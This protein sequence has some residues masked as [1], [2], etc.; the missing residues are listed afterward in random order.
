MRHIL[1]IL[2]FLLLSSFLVSCEKKEGTLYYHTSP[3]YL[4]FEDFHFKKDE[5]ED[6]DEDEYM[7]HKVSY[8]WIRRSQYITSI[9]LFY[10]NR[11]F[12]LEGF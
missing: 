8:K 5:D 6:E 4:D 2:S 9:G 10:K 7:S 11:G 12:Y 3:M 1:I